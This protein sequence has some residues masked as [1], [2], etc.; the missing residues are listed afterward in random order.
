MIPILLLTSLLAV[1]PR[2][3]FEDAYDN[4]ADGDWYMGQ[5]NTSANLAWGESY[6]MSA[7][8]AMFRATRHPMYLER[9]AAHADAVLQQRDDALGAT[10]YRGVSG[11]CWRNTSYQAGGEPYCYAVHTGMIVQ[12]MLEFVAAL[13][14]EPRFESRVAPD[15]ETLGEKAERYLVAAQESVAFHEFEWNP[16]GYYVFAPDATFL[17]YAGQD[18]PLNQSNALGRV[19]VLLAELAPGGDDEAKA[20]ALASRM[21]SMITVGGDGAYLWNYWG[22]PYAGNGED[23]SHA[24]INAD[25]MAL[26]AAH[27]LV[28]DEAD[29]RGLAT[30]FMERVYVNDGTFSDWVGGGSTNDPGYRPQVGRWLAL[31]RARTGVY[32]AVRD[33][34]DADYPSGG[35]GS[36]SLLL[37]W[38]LLAEHEPRLCAPYFYVVDWDD[39][40]DARQA[41][42]YGANL[43][44]VPPELSQP[45]A[46]EVTFDAA[47]VTDVEQWDGDAYHR[48]A[49]WRATAGFVTRH[50][51]YDPSWP[52]V[53]DGTGVLFQFADAFVPGEGIVVSEPR[54]LVLPAI[55]TEPALA[56]EVGVPWAYA[57]QGTGDPPY[58]WSL[59]DSP[60]DAD[61]DPATGAMSWTPPAIGSYAFTVRLANDV[62]FVEQSFVIDLVDGG[63]DES[64]DG[65]TD[66]ASTGGEATGAATDDGAST[67]G[68]GDATGLPGGTEDDATDGCSCRTRGEG[69]GSAWWGLLWIAPSLWWARRSKSR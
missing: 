17:A 57:P 37:G 29:V 59:T 68:M 50:I 69:T 38:A 54:Q 66:A 9:L 19:H 10:D 42:A 13:R 33:L 7:L 67:T 4:V 62:G 6:V 14:T 58:W 32:T 51:P 48:G 28:F 34:Y 2:W 18:Q 35:I 22:G 23:V 44:T 11:A 26:C 24:A 55:T 46:V 49:T 52:F 30:T 20:I 64:G 40:G 27:G 15:G 39:L 25:F 56:A 53:Y 12:P 31:S 47:R 63:L 60:G 5:D 61:I 43:L 21:Q 3:S 65:G 36:G 1:T 45:C 16:A 8:A 41:T